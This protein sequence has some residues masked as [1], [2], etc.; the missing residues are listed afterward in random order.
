MS[1]ENRLE[2]VRDHFA[3]LAMQG[4]IANKGPY[5]TT[6]SD[7]ATWAY[8]YADAMIK[9]KVKTEASIMQRREISALAT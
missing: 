1:I 2:L 4:I 3:G 9:E 7:I 5:F 6:H 8:D